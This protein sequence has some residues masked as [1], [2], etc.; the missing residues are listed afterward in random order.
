MKRFLISAAALALPS[1]LA[2]QQ[3]DVVRGRVVD[4]SARAIAGAAV[5]ITRGPDR[6]TMSDTTDATGSYR[7]RFEQGT[8]DYLVYISAT[9]FQSARRR[10]QRQN[11]ETELVADFTLTR[12]VA[13]L[14]AVRVSARRPVR[15]TR[16]V[17]PTQPDPGSTEK[18]SDGIVGAV[19]PTAAGDLNATAGTMSNVTL[20][21]TGASILG[22]G[23]ESNLNTLNGMAMAS[24][25]IPRA[26]RTETRVTGATFDPTRGGFAGANIDVRLGP[27]DRNFQRRNAFFTLDPQAW[28]FA[29]P[30][31]RAL[32]APSGG[33]KASFGADG[34]LI[35]RA[36]TYNVAVDVARSASEPAT[37]LTASA[38][39]LRLAGVSPD[40]V[41][42]LLAISSPLGL[43]VTASGIPSYRARNGVTWLGRL[44]DTRDTMKIRALTSYLG[45]TRESALGFGP[46]AAPSS[47]GERKERTI[48]GQLTMGEYV[49][50]GDR[51]LTET[52][53]AASAVRTESE[54]YQQ[55]PAANVLVRSA[56]GSSSDITSLSLGGG[57]FVATNDSRWTVEGMNETLWNA[58]GRTHRFKAHLSARADGLE[59]EGVSNNFGTFSFGSID[60]LEAN[61]PSSFSRTLSQQSRSGSVWN[62]AAALAHFYTHSRFFSVLYGARVEADGFF[63]SPAR[64]V[65]LEQALGV[66]TGAAPSRVHISPR[67]GFTWM[68]SKSRENGNGTNQTPVGRFYRT[69]SGV[70]RGGIGEFRDLLR[71]G[72]LSDANGT[73]T[74]TLSCVGAAVPDVDWE[75]FAANPASIPTQCADGSGALAERA[76]S[77]TLID[78]G[79]DVPRSWRASLDWS[80][81]V[82]GSVL[83]RLGGLAS[84]DLSQPGTVD[85]NF[86]G[87]SRF[88]LD[89]EGGRPVFV[90]PSGIDPNSGSVS[91]SESR[92][93]SDFGRVG[94]RVSDLRGYGGQ[95]TLGISPDVFR[96][97]PAFSLYGSASYT[98]Q[99]TRRQ[100]RGFDGA[101]FG[102]PRVKEWAPAPTDAR[103][104]L[105]LTGG[106]NSRK[107]GTL[108][109]FARAQSGLPFTPIVQGDVNGDG[110]SGDRAFI[111][112]P[113][114][115]ADP[116]VAAGL[117]SILESGEEGAR[118]CLAAQ[119][120]R[121]ASRNGCRGPWTQ[122]LNLQWRPPM[123]SKW[124]GRI[125]PTLYLQNIL[126]GVDQALHGTGSLR[127][128]GSQAVPDPVL[129][130]PKG[131]DAAQSRFRYDVN[132][133]FGQTRGSRSVGRDPF[134]IV[135]DFSINLSTDFDLQT[136]RRAVEP[137]RSETGW[138]RRSA[139]S[140][141]AFYLRQTSS[142]HK[143]LIRESDSLF[144]M[145]DQLVSLRT[146]D[147]VFSE[148]VRAIY[149]PLGQFLAQ[150]SGSAGKAELD[151]V[152][153]V[154]KEY[155]KIFWEQPEIAAAIVNPTQRELIPMFQRILEVPM[156]DRRNSQWQFGNPVTFSDK[157]PTPPPASGTGQ[158]VQ[159][160][161]VPND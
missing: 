155:W 90:S 75:S 19:A 36:M 2:A 113:A 15:A 125:R 50:P 128:W 47:A 37:L 18:W 16:T 115:V 89:G 25:S 123:P 87:T 44:D 139:D 133:R 122:S 150:G 92:I 21:P 138:Q 77:I 95:L 46:L 143:L 102:D 78:P 160:R 57:S 48:G 26:A 67:A 41:A 70:V 38:D 110:R 116:A 118:E 63:D 152:A 101:G 100:F 86:G 82:L 56:T 121:A 136:L 40:S 79:Y 108:T 135:L 154:Q 73:G 94:T 96:Y 28:Q 33:F 148:R 65:A 45:Y 85:A 68:Y 42:R 8:G 149:M 144:L 9:G 39:A 134:R 130:I 66:H 12:A 51:I 76:P 60:D 117:R 106:F 20:T 81:N 62:T 88:S 161:N 53:I 80:T 64:N 34:E 127:G 14:D 145:R 151:S 13:E 105:V 129:L 147:S 84:Y 69:S 153:K 156:D 158:S 83:M 3:P 104:V 31:G 1:V 93:S 55:Q 157:Q 54:P 22:S 114:N 146:A 97:R 119:L 23:S 132:P 29:D 137:V 43:P 10:V 124:G 7:V 27:G 126:A 71:P 24:G 52:R 4:D 5:M 131:F 107:A 30:V 58:R 32:G 103:H 99:W 109:L 59:Q 98:L 11:T 159:V 120:G 6:L 141:A 91:P 17:S 140:L 72:I 111:P 49:G 142:I 61:R 35:R 112:D 74:S